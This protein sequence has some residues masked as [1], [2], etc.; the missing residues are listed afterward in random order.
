[1]QCWVF[2][3]ISSLVV[4]SEFIGIFNISLISLCFHCTTR[5]ASF[6]IFN[7]FDKMSS[8]ERCILYFIWLTFYPKAAKRMNVFINRLFNRSKHSKSTS[9]FYWISFDWIHQIHAGKS[10]RWKP[11][12]EMVKGNLAVSTPRND[13]TKESVIMQIF[14]GLRFVHFSIKFRKRCKRLSAESWN[15]ISPV[16][17]SSL[18]HPSKQPNCPIQG[19]CMCALNS[20]F[21][22][23]YAAIIQISYIMYIFNAWGDGRANK[24]VNMRH[25]ILWKSNRGKTSMIDAKSIVHEKEYFCLKE[26]VEEYMRKWNSRIS[27]FRFHIKVD[28]VWFSNQFQFKNNYLKFSRLTFRLSWEE[29]SFR[30]MRNIEKMSVK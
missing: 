13:G 8:S 30:S 20:Y 1:M 2:W 29:N 28:H 11:T 18:A 9:K 23:P 17:F 14:D 19:I 16:E 24:D 10:Y 15:F 22:F 4:L 5:K 26:C 7:D 12:M 6:Q 27:T 25:Y 21:C 3:K